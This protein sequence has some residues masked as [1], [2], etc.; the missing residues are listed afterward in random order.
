MV[1]AESSTVNVPA[2]LRAGEAQ[3]GPPTYMSNTGRG[4]AGAV[5]GFLTESKPAPCWYRQEKWLR[6]VHIFTEKR[7]VSQ[8]S[9]DSQGIPF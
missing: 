6:N 3:Q 7:W 9:L 1:R 8:L 4:P 5:G 2:L